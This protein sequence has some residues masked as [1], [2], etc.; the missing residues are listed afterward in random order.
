MGSQFAVWGWRIPFL[1][2][3]ILIVIGLYIRF[4]IF[5]TPL[6]TRFLEE[7]RPSRL[8]LSD[9]LRHNWKEILLSAGAKFTEQAPLYIFQT[10]VITYGV[11]N[12]HLDKQLLLMGIYIGALL[13]VFT[14]P[15]FSRLSDRI[16]R[17]TCYLIGCVTMLL[18]IFP[19]FLLL[20]TRNPVLVVGSIVASFGIFHGLVYG[21]Q[22]ALI[23][24]QFKTKFRYSG[25][26]LG[27][28]LSAPFAG[29]LGPIIALALLQ[30]YHS[31]VPVAL[32]LIAIAIFS[33]LCVLGLKEM[34]RTSIA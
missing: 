12:L 34:A 2:S 6:F 26:S 8:P 9:A 24:E 27:Y 20:N 4:R 11:I 25:A 1:L 31:Y 17:R 33:F 32:F 10:F 3:A 30:S 7:H 15:L 22:A 16:G 19:Y 28:Q 21:P 29:G 5:E 18:Y 14:I 13:E 23:S